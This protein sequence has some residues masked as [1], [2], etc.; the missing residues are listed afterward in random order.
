[1]IRNSCMRMCREYESLKDERNGVRQTFRIQHQRRHPGRT[2]TYP[3]HLQ[4][5]PPFTKW[6]RQ[7]VQ[8]L[9]EA[10]FPL[11]EKLI[12]LST[13]PSA[14]AESY[15][16]MWS[17]GALLRCMEDESAR[18]YSTFD[19]GICTSISE[20]A[21]DRIEVGILKGIYRVSFAG[22][23]VIILRTEWTKQDLLR[24]DC[25]GFWS[26]KLDIR[27]DRR[28]MNPFILPVNVEQ[29]FF[30]E[31]VLS[32]DRKIVLGHEPRSRRVVGNS[33]VAFSRAPSHHDVDQVGR[34]TDNHMTADQTEEIRQVPVSRVNELDANLTREED[35]SHF[36]DN[37]YEDDP[38]CDL[39]G[40]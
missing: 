12:Q 28:R 26:C 25:M 18:G 37:Q 32:A 10:D 22:W 3:V 4:S 24:K 13:P 35:D 14:D 40:I 39:P 33:E 29:V 21:V 2:V 20:R 7:H 1:M 16:Y 19:S 34:T 36:D 23:N 6:L 30:M 31:D 38:E 5:M 9:R 11:D 8:E 27:E 17:Y 15:K